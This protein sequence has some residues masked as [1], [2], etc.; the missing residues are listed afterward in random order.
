MGAEGGGA[1][2]LG[3]LLAANAERVVALAAD[4]V[5]LDCMLIFKTLS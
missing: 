5:V 1:F 3:A 4:L 2:A